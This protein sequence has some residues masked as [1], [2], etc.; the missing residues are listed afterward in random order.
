MV[1]NFMT[2]NE[3]AEYDTWF[4]EQVKKGLSEARNPKNLIPHAVA[5][6]EIRMVIDRLACESSQQVEDEGYAGMPDHC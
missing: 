1:T 3:T 6:K 2:N 5:I 4:R